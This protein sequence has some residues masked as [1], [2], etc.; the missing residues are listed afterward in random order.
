MVKK[1]DLMN[2]ATNFALGFARKQ[3]IEFGG[4]GGMVTANDVICC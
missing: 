1:I 4:S 2:H 3:S